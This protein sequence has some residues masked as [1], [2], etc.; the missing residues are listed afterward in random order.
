MKTSKRRIYSMLKLRLS[1]WK[2]SDIAR[3]YGISRERVGQI[4]GRKKYLTR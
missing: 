2:D 3:K 4:L 1:G